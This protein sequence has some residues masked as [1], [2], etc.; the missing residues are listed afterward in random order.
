M[1][2]SNDVNYWEKQNKGYLL[3]QLA[4]RGYRGDTKKTVRMTK[5]TSGINRNLPGE[6]NKK[7]RSLVNIG[8]QKRPNKKH[9][10]IWLPGVRYGPCL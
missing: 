2:K 5:K 8:I 9:P 10:I 1:D 6:M 3:D 7:N 4:A